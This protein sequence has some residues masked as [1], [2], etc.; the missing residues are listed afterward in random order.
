VADWRVRFC[1]GVARLEY[2]NGGRGEIKAQHNN[3]RRCKSSMYIVKHH[4][5]LIIILIAILEKK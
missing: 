3:G 2:E 1:G 5:E 4:Q